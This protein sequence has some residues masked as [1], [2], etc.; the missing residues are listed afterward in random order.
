MKFQLYELEHVIKCNIFLH[1]FQ[2]FTMFF[3]FFSQTLY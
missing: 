2:K 1:M 3:F